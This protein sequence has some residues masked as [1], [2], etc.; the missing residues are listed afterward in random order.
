MSKSL[1]KILQVGAIVVTVVAAIPTF[2]LSAGA[3]A[4]IGAGIAAATV[5]NSAILA[6]K[7][8][9]ALQ[10]RQASIT[11]VSLGERPMYIRES[12]A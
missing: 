11:A 10:A 7:M 9:D 3:A 8:K 6:S 5:A 12:E 1:G 2:G 4:I